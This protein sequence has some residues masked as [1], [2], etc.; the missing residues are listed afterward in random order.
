MT[1][2]QRGVCSLPDCDQPHHARTW[3][4]LHYYRWYHHGDPKWVPS[5]PP[6]PDPMPVTRAEADEAIE[7]LR[8]YVSKTS[9]APADGAGALIKEIPQPTPGERP[10]KAE[11]S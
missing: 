1:G 6:R 3:C 10:G 5:R 11:P 2:R 9:K 8:S 7:S 4:V